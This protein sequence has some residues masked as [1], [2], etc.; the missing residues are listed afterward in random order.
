M[1]LLIALSLKEEFGTRVGERGTGRASN[2]N[3]FVLARVLHAVEPG[4]YLL[5]PEH[6]A[7]LGPVRGL[8]N[9]LLTSSAKQ[10]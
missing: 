4:G 3:D 1:I 7:L 6:R 8:V 9:W 10:R 5:L 2:T